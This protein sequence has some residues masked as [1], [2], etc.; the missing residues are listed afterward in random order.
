MEG[1][2]RTRDQLPASLRRISHSYVTRTTVK[3][4][5]GGEI[6]EDWE[7]AKNSSSVYRYPA[8]V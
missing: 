7:P 2:R 8:S 5:L 1:A 3:G 4:Q 6:S